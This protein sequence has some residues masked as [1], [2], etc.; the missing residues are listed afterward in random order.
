MS[1][2]MASTTPTRPA[3]SAASK[4]SSIHARPAAT[5]ASTSETCSAVGATSSAPRRTC[6]GDRR[7]PARRHRPPPGRRRGPVAPLG[8]ATVP[9]R[10]GWARI[11]SGGWR[12]ARGTR[13]GSGAL[14]SVGP[15]AFGARDPARLG[16]RRR[17]DGDRTLPAGT[18]P[19]DRNVHD[20][21]SRARALAIFPAAKWV[22]AG[23]T[24]LSTCWFV[25]R[26]AVLGSGRRTERPP[27]TVDGG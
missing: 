22:T 17:D 10:F 7:L 1:A 23:I 24:H 13:P 11:G 6:H 5:R 9:A 15:I 18:S 3:D 4:V 2:C 14:V 21:G 27:M 25:V 26:S 19:V 8:C 20:G 16:G 12:A